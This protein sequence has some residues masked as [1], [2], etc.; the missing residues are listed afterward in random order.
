MFELIFLGGAV[1]L[2]SGFFGIGGGTITVP[3]LLMF[4]YE[5]KTAIG[6][7][8]LQMVFS[9]IYGSYLNNKKGTLDIAMI[10]FIGVGGFLGASLSGYITSA[11][12]PKVLETMFLVFAIFALLRLFFKIKEHKDQKEV[13]RF[14]LF[15]I[16]FILGSVSIAIGLGGSIVLIPILVGF[17]HVPLKKAISAGLFFVIF[18]SISGFISHSMSGNVD[19]ESGVVLGLSSLFGVYFG[20]MFKDKIDTNLQRKMLI[21]YYFLVVLYLIKRI[22]F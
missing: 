10:S 16:G 17:L 21:T 11:L 2:L 12:D 3:I 4:G 18:S 7:S 19:Y 13:N 15:L 8:I 20:I 1:G 6:I 14:V 9:S 22:Y 5:V